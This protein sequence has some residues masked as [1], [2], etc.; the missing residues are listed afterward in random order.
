MFIFDET[1]SLDKVTDRREL[2][3]HKL[4]IE[5]FMRRL[6]FHLLLQLQNKLFNLFIS[7]CLCSS[8]ED[9]A[10]TF[11][12]FISVRNAN[13]RSKQKQAKK[14]ISNLLCSQMGCLWRRITGL[15]SMFR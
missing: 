14:C 6:I 12:P 5:P 11:L 4:V 9:N 3:F 8:D 2:Y 1:K 13:Y 10:Q 15:L 7:I